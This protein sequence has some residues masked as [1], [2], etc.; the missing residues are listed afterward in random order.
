VA[1]LVAVGAVSWS[2]TFVAAGEPN[3]LTS[4]TAAISAAPAATAAVTAMAFRLGDGRAGRFLLGRS[5]VTGEN[6]CMRT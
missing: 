2:L 1:P 4:T 3:G 5:C 6:G